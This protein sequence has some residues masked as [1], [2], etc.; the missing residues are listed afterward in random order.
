[1]WN[2]DWLEAFA[3]LTIRKDENKDE[4]PRDGAAYSELHEL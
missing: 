1:M 4:D 3:S 2:V